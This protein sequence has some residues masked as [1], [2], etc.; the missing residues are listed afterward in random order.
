MQFNYK[1]NGSSAVTSTAREVGMSFAPDVFR[2]PTFFIGK[3]GKHLPFRE[4]MSALHD[5]VVSDLRFTP[6]DK[7]DYKAWAAQQE[8]RWLAEMMAGSAD[9]KA[10]LSAVNAELEALRK[11]KNLIMEPFDRAKREYFQYLYKR[12][13]EAWIVLDPVITVHPDE[14]FFEC[15]SRDES[16]YGRL[17]CDYNVF[18]EINEFECG[19]TNID[20]SSKLYQE[21]QKIREYKETSLNIDPTG[22]EVKTAAEADYKEVKIDLPDS[23]VR[24]FLQVSSA[25]A[26]PAIRVD[27]HPMDMHN[28]LFV[29]K[30]RKEKA[31]PRSM[32]YR[33]T[34]GEPVRV[35]FEPWNEEIVCLRSIYAGNEAVEVRVWGRRRLMMLERL[36][37]MARRFTVTLLGTGLPS[38]YMADL[39]D[40][41]FTL[42]LSGWTANDWSRQGNFDLLAPRADVDSLTQQQVY[43]ALRQNW[44]E[45]ADSLASRLNLERKTVLGALSA[46][47]QAGRAI[48]DLN[49]QVYRIRELSREALP[50]EKFRFANER[51]AAAAKLL[52]R[53]AVTLTPPTL[54]D[55]MLSLLGTVKDG[56]RMYAPD[57]AIDADE[58]LARASCTCNFYQ[59]NKLTKG[60]CEHILALRMW[61]GRMTKTI[62]L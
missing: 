6:K 9:V 30:R 3:L 20:Y 58:R 2:E 7:T 8:E 23:W 40:M 4:A 36:I 18:K 57:L 14:L 35:L 59:Q 39:G 42:G 38:F 10:R 46:F 12:D 48:F 52:E 24:G 47:T 21:F 37:P 51:E 33:L 15:F 25:M 43:L 41:T 45:D 16:S 53:N 60:P 55:G 44:R 56:D 17:S 50:V 11:D 28:F 5:V 13:I 61:H 19:T 1:F 26:L 31:S 32:R 22:F 27:L 49:K 29:L 34:P 62:P 54:S